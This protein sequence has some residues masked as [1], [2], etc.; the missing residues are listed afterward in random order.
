ME[1]LGT[2]P[3]IAGKN[4]ANPTAILL[5]ATMVFLSIKLMFTPLFLLNTCFFLIKINV[6]HPFFEKKNRCYHIWV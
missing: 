6:L 4:L 2:A 3:D 1:Y 5:S